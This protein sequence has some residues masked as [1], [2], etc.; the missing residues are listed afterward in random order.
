MS[1]A[2]A[3]L[4]WL[5]MLRLALVQSAIGAVVVLATSTLNRVMIVE[6]RLP[7]MLPAALI[8][9]HYV[10]QLL[11]PRVGHGADQGGRCTPWIVAGMA[12]LA[13]GGALAAF[14]TA[15]MV[16]SRAFG[17]VL[18]LIAYVA[19]GAGVGTAGTA[20]L[21]LLTKRV[22]P[23]RRAT[24]ATLVWVMMIAG[25]GLCAGIAGRL[26]QP[27]SPARLVEVVTVASLIALCVTILA[28]WN[29][30][31]R[32]APAR[33]GDA[34]AARTAADA[35]ARP[36][37]SFAE[38]LRQ[39]W[40]EPA[41]RAFT[42][43]LFTSMLAYSAQELLVESFVGL[44]FGFTPG[45]S[46]QLAGLQHGAVMIGMVSIALIGSRLGAG[47]FRRFIVVGTI[48]SALALVMLA[49]VS[50]L[51]ARPL[52]APVVFALG[53]AN[54]AFAVAALSA[55]MDLSAAGE[56]GTEGMRMGVWGAAQAVAF[57]FGGL[58]AGGAV[59]LSRRLWHSPD[60]AYACVFGAAALLFAIASRHALR[61]AAPAPTALPHA[62][63][64]P[65]LRCAP[66]GTGSHP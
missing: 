16:D 24:A 66:A 53:L 49:L 13:G 41:A 22:A 30:E 43:F 44:V 35:T 39:L 47:A 38:A 21:T 57:A 26:L 8:A 2:P 33:T 1:G 25:F 40:R 54:G 31:R 18:A 17:I 9:I 7:A 14:A 55:M 56:R 12:L 11:R 61:V 23:A 15:T 20:N 36:G 37:R 5:G 65:A 51:A 64:A 52:L 46:A 60:I 4:G 6:L 42:L 10:V 3:P 63:P 34:D 29:M 28:V 27:F 50:A 48:A 45:Q 62:S 59:D 19:I 32:V 58:G